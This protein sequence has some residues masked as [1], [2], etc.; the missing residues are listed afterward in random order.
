[1]SNCLYCYRPLDAGHTDYHP[2][3]S[4][5]FFGTPDAPALPYRLDDMEQLAKEAIELSVTVLQ[6]NEK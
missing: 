1:M 5:A 6:L 3:C 2:K 4:M